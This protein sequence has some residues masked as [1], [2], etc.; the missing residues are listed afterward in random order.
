M[1]EPSISH[2]ILACLEFS[3]GIAV[4]SRISVQHGRHIARITLRVGVSAHSIASVCLLAS[5]A[6]FWS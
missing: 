3:A 1:L 6:Q 2:A 5:L 4:V